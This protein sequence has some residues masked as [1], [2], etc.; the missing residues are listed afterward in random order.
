MVS[1]LAEKVPGVVVADSSLDSADDRFFQCRPGRL[2]SEAA[3]LL[4]R[5]V[6][7]ASLLTS[8]LLPC[9]S[10]CNDSP[11]ELVINNK[12]HDKKRAENK[13]RNMHPFCCYHMICFLYSFL[14]MLLKTFSSKSFLARDGK[15]ELM[16]V[17]AAFWTCAFQESLTE[18]IVSALVTEKQ[19]ARLLS[20][21]VCFPLLTR[22]HQS[23]RNVT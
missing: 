3:L 4:E 19:H 12:I 10:S 18:K 22:R 14:L 6:A 17:C 13:D 5:N 23:V 7:F 15:S 20:S 16:M 8:T 21:H 11:S 1:P 2:D 9:S